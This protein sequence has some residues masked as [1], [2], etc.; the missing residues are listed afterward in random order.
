MSSLSRRP[1][2]KARDISRSHSKP[3]TATKREA[4]ENFSFEYCSASSKKERRE[5]E[6][7]EN[8]GL[9]FP[10][11]SQITRHTE[12]DPEACYFSLCSFARAD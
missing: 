1:I 7:S 10:D 9:Q 8:E 6:S 12:I 2:A 5:T 3:I 4:V 11:C